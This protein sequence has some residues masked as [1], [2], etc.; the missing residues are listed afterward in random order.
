M[1]Y[2]AIK[3]SI[4]RVD[5]PAF[6]QLMAEIEPIV[7]VEFATVGKTRLAIE[8][9]RDNFVT[10][11]WSRKESCWKTYY[12]SY[13]EYMITSNEELEYIALRMLDELWDRME[14]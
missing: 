8:K 4:N 1:T 12:T 7:F 13:F 2:E 14:R 10:K 5:L 11:F 3:I 6:A 9:D